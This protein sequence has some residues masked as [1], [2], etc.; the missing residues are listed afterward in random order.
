[1]KITRRRVLQGGAFAATAPLFQTTSAGLLIDAANAQTASAD[2]TWRHGLSL[3]GDIKYPVGFKHFDYVNAD[4]PKGGRM[5]T[6]GTGGANTFDTL[7]QFL[8]L[9]HI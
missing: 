3:F 2:A 9:I 7:N 8:S 1:M 4:A 6:M 5:V